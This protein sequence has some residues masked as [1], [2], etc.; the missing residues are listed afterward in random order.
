MRGGIWEKG[1]VHRTQERRYQAAKTCIRLSHSVVV[2]IMSI[3]QV[4]KQ[5]RKSL[6]VT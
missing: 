4:K 5:L 3:S 6:A 2:T 1:N